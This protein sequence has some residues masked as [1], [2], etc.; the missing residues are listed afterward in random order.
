MGKGNFMDNVAGKFSLHEETS[1]K[2]IILG[3][4]ATMYHPVKTTCFQHKNLQKGTWKWNTKKLKNPESATN[5]RTTSV[6]LKGH[7]EMSNIQV[8]WLSVKRVMS[9]VTEKILVKGKPGIIMMI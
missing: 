1:G 5:M 7:E 4:L 8:Q 3:H 6:T 2:G 9:Q